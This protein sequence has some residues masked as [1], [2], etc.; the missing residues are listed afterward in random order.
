MSKGLFIT[1]TGTDV[2]KTYVSAL[3]VRAMH[4]AGYSCGY[5]KA[6]V[7]GASSLED[8]DAGFVK[9]FANMAQT[10]SNLLSYRYQT[11]V[12]PHLAAQWEG[13]PLCMEKVQADY[14]AVCQ[15]Y[16]FVVVEGS[17]GIVCPLRWDEKE[18]ILLEDVV[19][20]LSLPALVV[21]HSGLGSIN[22]SV[23]TVHYLKSRNIP[24]HGMILNRFLGTPMEEDNAKM[25]ET[26]TG[27]PILVRVKEQDEQLSLTKECLAT[28]F[29]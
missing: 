17:G 20:A 13:N 9:R 5:Y 2:G 23:L 19:K 11:P 12:S 8:S 25:I 6:A 14:Q 15:E 1:A 27:V 3:L 26:L 4:Q 24:I 7:S 28:L 22:A 29:A 16:P 21:S 18:Q 10:D